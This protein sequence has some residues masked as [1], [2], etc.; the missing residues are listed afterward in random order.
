MT[1][2]R[3]RFLLNGVTLSIGDRTD[4]RRGG[5]NPRALGDRR[6]AFRVEQRDERLADGQ[7]G[8]GG[9]DI[10]LR[11]RPQGFSGCFHGLLIARREGAERVL[12]AI[13]ELPQ[14]RVGDVRRTL[15]DEVHADALRPD[16]THDLLDFLHQGCRGVGE[17]QVRLVEK[18]DKRGL[19]RISDLRQAL[20]QLR[21]HPQQ[22]RRVELRRS[23]Q[24]VGDEDVD[25]AAAVPIGLQQ[26]I[27]VEH[28]LAEQLLAALLLD[29]EERA[30]D[31]AD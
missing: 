31:G 30:L 19:V 5:D 15:R 6:A 10:E 9:S 24:L 21:Q 12:D 3:R 17:E 8:D 14:H 7:F 28:R 26:I 11:V 23:D 20:E 18:E 4:L 2:D 1:V 22:E 29:L 25:H 16:Q 27:D 13:A